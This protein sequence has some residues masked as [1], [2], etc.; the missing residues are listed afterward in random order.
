MMRRLPPE[1]DGS[2]EILLSLIDIECNTI[3]EIRERLE[4][5]MD[6]KHNLMML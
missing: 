6:R 1:P 2:H 4:F 3:R 5:C